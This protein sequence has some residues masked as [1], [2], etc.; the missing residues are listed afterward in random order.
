MLKPKK[1]NK[2]ST[3]SLVL[4][5]QSG[6]VA[7]EVAAPAPAAATM[8]APTLSL[9]SIMK[10]PNDPKELGKKKTKLRNHWTT[11]LFQRCISKI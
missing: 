5:T 4:T 6:L 10:R 8:F 11:I 1:A 7:I 3:I 2:S 9:P